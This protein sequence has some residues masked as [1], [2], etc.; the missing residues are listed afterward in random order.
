M[1]TKQPMSE[2]MSQVAVV[3]PAAVGGA[4]IVRAMGV[5][6]SQ[7]PVASL[8]VAI[9]GV[10]FGA[11]VMELWLR[12]RRAFA[13]GR[14]V[15]A[16]PRK[17]TEDLLDRASA[18]L[19]AFL[20][21]R[22]EHAPTPALGE[23]LT[24]YL[25]GFMVMLGLLGTLLGLFETLH[26]AGQAL[27][28]SAD[29][30]ALRSGLSGPMR[31]LT[32]SFGCSAAGVSASAMLGLA[33]VFVRRAEG[34]A[35]ARAQSFATGPL[36]ELSPM[37]R[38]LDSFQQLAQ[39]GESLPRAAVSLEQAS[40]HLGQLAE[41][42]ES[43]HR[44]TLEAQQKSAQELMEKMRSELA[45]TSLDAGRA[46]SE[47]VA[48]MLKQVVAQTGEALTRQ[49]GANREALDKD[50]A[51]RREA[52]KAL[53][54]SLREELACSRKEAQT[55]LATLAEAAQKL[56]GQLEEEA[57]HRRSE[58]ERL[59]G[60]LSGRLDAAAS[61][62]AEENRGELAALSALGE[63]LVANS[64][65]RESEL[66]G[67]WSKLVDRIKSDLGELVQ[68][69]GQDVDARAERDRQLTQGVERS[70]ETLRLGAEG[71]STLATKQEQAVH[72]LV[73]RSALQL[74]S[75]GAA[76]QTS[77][78][79]ALDTLVKL[80]EEQAMRALESEAAT[81]E[82]A[83]SALAKLAKLGEDQAQ[84]AAQLET[85]AQTSSREVLDQ[86]VRLGE[87]HQLRVMQLG[88]DHA[89]R[90]VQ[91]ETLLQ[92]TQAQH[93]QS[94]AGELTDHAQRLSKGLETTTG[95]VQEAATVLRASSVEMRRVAALFHQ[96]VER[97]R[98]ASQAWMESLGEL[99][100]AVERAGR[101][102]A[103]DAL[104]DQLA[105]TQEVFARQL[106]FQRE[107]FEQLRTLRSASIAPARCQGRAR[108]IR[109]RKSK[110]VP[111]PVSPPSAI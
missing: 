92:S 32:R 44:A 27:T 93:T 15:D 108:C 83:R 109:L 111:C 4:V 37:R 104:G 84:R 110:P 70:L 6:L 46:L 5:Y 99:E 60:E 103:A 76:A 59:L 77:S 61:A 53:R 9:M 95:L 10:G 8:I 67:R 19:K 73:Q 22:I 23:N 35:W 81:Q 105:S 86:L 54:E 107:L 16:L 39:Q 45:R 91:L 64:Q 62:R 68:S 80:G 96:S 14:E 1:N 89:A 31:G 33:A 57:R 36:R 100:G 79:E 63:Q 56:S 55:H 71:L 69:I 106:Q 34:N 21:A 49:M 24:P 94:L 43:A 48:P 13:L 40:T 85:H 17:I 52:D 87:E 82:S 58:A 47:S 29:V 102:A 25:V 98:E 101:G 2:R 12:N 18:P 50:L 20:R 65:Q 11:G 38:Q 28:A 97:Q 75:F 88:E 90:F 72:E 26:G 30:N 78:R 42:W 41:R 74:E 51:V 3:L 7:D 66:A